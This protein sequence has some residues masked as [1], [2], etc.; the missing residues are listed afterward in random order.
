MLKGIVLG[1]FSELHN[2]KYKLLKIFGCTFIIMIILVSFSPF[3]QTCR[4]TGKV[5]TKKLKEKS[6]YWSSTTL[7]VIWTLVGI[8]FLKGKSDI[9][10]SAI[11]IAYVLQSKLSVSID[12]VLQE[13]GMHFSWLCF[14]PPSKFL[15]GVR[16]EFKLTVD[17][18]SC[19]WV[20]LSAS[21]IQISYYS[22]AIFTP[23]WCPSS[24]WRDLTLVRKKIS[25]YSMP[26]VAISNKRLQK[27]DDLRC[28]SELSYA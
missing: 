7:I 24:V 3:V 26:T 16:R 27:H 25:Y 8:S 6:G 20:W 1:I 12:S 5:M 19:Q 13:Y 21:G 18:W 2:N 14:R 17:R 23:S 22:T 9:D 15:Q 11:D 28:C 4:L 10:T